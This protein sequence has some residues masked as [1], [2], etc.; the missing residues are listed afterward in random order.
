MRRFVIVG[1]SIACLA[2]A[3]RLAAAG[4][5]VVVCEQRT[6]WNRPDQDD[7]PPTLMTMPQVLR[8]FVAATGAPW[9]L[10][11][12]PSHT[13][14]RHRLPGGM[15]LDFPG[16]DTERDIALRLGRHAAS[17]WSRFCRRIE[18]VYAEHVGR[19]LAPGLHR[20][21]AR[22]PARQPTA[23]RWISRTVR[24]VGLRE[25]IRREAGGDHTD[26]RTAPRSRLTAP[27]ATAHFGVWAV[28]GGFEGLSDALDACAR[29]HGAV[30]LTGARVTWS[31]AAAGA[32]T[33]HLATGERLPADVVVTTPGVASALRCTSEGT[34]RTGGGPPAGTRPSG[35]GLR[36]HL[37]DGAD[38]LGSGHA[39]DLLAA[40]AA[41]DKIG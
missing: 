34:G 1:S 12:R 37:L 6:G 26:L 25:V 18:P 29:R 38:H 7:R 21:P 30:I 5:R 14:H 23:A 35:H 19:L 13:L 33:V 40:K 15:V 36:L 24:H 9:V 22:A 10:E 16:V 31:A 17:E 8:E 41:V 4:H 39:Y 28:A 32:G 11:D 27:F 2:T 3:A 20:S